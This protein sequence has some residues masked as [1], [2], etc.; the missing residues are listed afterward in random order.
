MD[1]PRRVGRPRLH[2]SAAEKQRAYRDRKDSAHLKVAKELS[3]LRQRLALAATDDEVLARA[4]RLLS[5]LPE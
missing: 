4:E 5:G 1:A 3:Q 2:E